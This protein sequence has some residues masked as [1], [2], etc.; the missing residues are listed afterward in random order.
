MP[1]NTSEQSTGIFYIASSRDFLEEATLS[2]R[3]VK[4]E[5]DWVPIA[6]GVS[7]ELKDAVPAVFDRTVELNKITKDFGDKVYNMMCSPFDRTIYFDS[8]IYIKDDV[9]EIF[10]SL[11]Q[12]DLAVAF[13]DTDYKF[14]S[15]PI[16]EDHPYKNIPD[17]V[18]EFNTG[19][20][21][22]KSN[23]RMEQV[24]TRWQNYYKYDK[25]NVKD[26]PPD[27]VS[28]KRAIYD[29]EIKY[30]T[31]PREYNC[32]F[33]TA[34]YVSD[35]VKIFHGRLIE[36]N[37]LGAEQSMNV[38][39]AIDNINGVSGI[40]VYFTS[41]KTIVYSGKNQFLNLFYKLYRRSVS[42]FDELVDGL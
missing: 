5:M 28:F 9:S 11:D 8:D 18:R 20:I 4:N 17:C 13:N 23:E 41:P 22:W 10:T 37:G 1:G 36:T 2:A 29:S 21:G 30:C 3:S 39:K 42:L 6:I 7:P 12:F 35:K 38:E 31:L 14:G 16:P 24:F 32:L 26:S 33:R 15:K 34:G 27:Q 40:R 25:E 19:V